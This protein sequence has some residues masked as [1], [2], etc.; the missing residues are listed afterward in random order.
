L[1]NKRAD[2]FLVVPAATLVEPAIAVLAPECGL[3]TH[4]PVLVLSQSFT[5]ELAD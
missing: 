4:T 5:R 1:F 3:N 2:G